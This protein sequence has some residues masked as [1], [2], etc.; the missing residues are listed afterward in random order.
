MGNLKNEP[1]AQVERGK[2]YA[3]QATAI[4]TFE[5]FGVDLTNV[6]GISSMT[7]QTCG[8]SKLTAAE[9][10]MPETLP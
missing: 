1:G 2:P 3:A 5:I 10:S 6:L 4:A 9:L 7:A 8:L